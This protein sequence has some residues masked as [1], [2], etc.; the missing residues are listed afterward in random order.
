MHDVVVAF[1]SEVPSDRLADLH[2]PDD[3]VVGVEAEAM[4]SEWETAE[5]GHILCSLPPLLSAGDC[6]RC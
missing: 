5:G 1:Q 4:R 2:V 6:V 3:S